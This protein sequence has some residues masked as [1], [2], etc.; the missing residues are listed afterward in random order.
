MGFVIGAKWITAMLFVCFYAR[1][2][3]TVPRRQPTSMGNERVSSVYPSATR[4]AVMGS[5]PWGGKPPVWGWSPYCMVPSGQEKVKKASPYW[6][7]TIHYITRKM[8]VGEPLTAKEKFARDHWATILEILVQISGGTCIPFIAK[9]PP[10]PAKCCTLIFSG[11]SYG[12]CVLKEF[13]PPPLSQTTNENNQ[14]NE[15][16]ETNETK[17]K[18]KNKRRNKRKHRKSSRTNTV[19]RTMLVETARTYF[20]LTS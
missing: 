7:P 11:V 20:S 10:K 16:N 17:N 8:M 1:I 5:S 6:V 13:L 12:I 3:E 18:K 4:N 15:T 19:S 2:A 14:T 9:V